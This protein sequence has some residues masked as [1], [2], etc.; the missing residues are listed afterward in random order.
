V[1]YIHNFLFAVSM[2]NLFPAYT[3]V[4]QPWNF[5]KEKDGIKIYTRNEPHSSLKSYKG[6]TIFKAPMPKVCAL[7]GT[8]NNFDWW[9][10]GFSKIEVLKH[11]DQ[12]FIQYYFI[13]DMPWPIADRDLAVESRIKMDTAS[14]I[15]TVS[16]R[17]L[18]KTVPEKPD[19]VRIKKYW[20]KWTVQPKENGNLRVTIEGSVDPGGNLPDWAYNLLITEMPLNTLHSL[21]KRVLSSSPV[22]K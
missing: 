21:R 7:L 17:P 22:K 14:G 6:E 13:Y 10:K 4:A 11:A 16:S 5:V 2:L 20:Q 8:A 9:D 12:K 15:Y 1:K 3:V 19:L 18:L